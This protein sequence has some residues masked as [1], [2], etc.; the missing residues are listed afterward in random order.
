MLPPD[1][2]KS[3]IHLGE[4]RRG[5]TCDLLCAELTQLCLQVDELLLQIILV[6][7]PKRIGLDFGRLLSMLA[8]II[9]IQVSVRTILNVSRCR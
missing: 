6:L 4:L 5:T 8:A 7:A 3:I 2:G 1:S 9:I